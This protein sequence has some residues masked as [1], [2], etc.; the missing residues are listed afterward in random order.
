MQGS[1]EFGFI[2]DTFSIRGF[3]TILSECCRWEPDCLATHNRLGHFTMFN[4]QLIKLGKT[5]LISIYS[6]YGYE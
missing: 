3:L 2:C 4:L 6:A 1:F 5:G